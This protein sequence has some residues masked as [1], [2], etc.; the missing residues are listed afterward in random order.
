MNLNLNASTNYLFSSLEADIVAALTD[1]SIG[2]ASKKEARILFEKTEAEINETRFPSVVFDALRVERS[3]SFRIP[4]KMAMGHAAST[5]TFLT[6]LIH[7]CLYHTLGK[8]EF[9]SFYIN[10]ISLELVKQDLYN[11]YFDLVLT[12]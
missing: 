12:C 11:Y 9:L 5:R 4:G 7:I 2:K 3:I 1:L 10:P 8:G 6:S